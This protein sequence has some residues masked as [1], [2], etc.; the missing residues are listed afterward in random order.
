[1]PSQPEHGSNKQASRSDS[2][3]WHNTIKVPAE[4]HLAHLIPIDLETV[5]FHPSLKLVNRTRR[6][7]LPIPDLGAAG[8]ALIYPDDD[9][10]R[11]GQYIKEPS[12][13]GLIFRNPKDGGIYQGVK[14]DGSKVLLFN[15]I[16]SEIAAAL[17]KK[18]LQTK[19]NID[20][21]TLADLKE[22]VRFAAQ[23]LKIGDIFNAKRSQVK[24][25]TQAVE[26][27]DINAALEDR[28]DFGYRV[29]S[30][31]TRHRVA[32]IGVVIGQDRGKRYASDA[33]VLDDGNYRWCI[34]RDVIERNFKKIVEP[35]AG[36]AVAEEPLKPLIEE[37]ALC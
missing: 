13:R 11:V 18:I 4:G 7:S 30:K 32:L 23:E 33:V 36:E 15:D 3:S 10:Q 34:A 27:F 1:M 31:M 21:L 35:V 9:P 8:E 26:G 2:P 19:S 17:M 6:F 24:N 20:E 29:V 16:S 22:I 25:D 37:F 12:D 14:A 5:T 28:N